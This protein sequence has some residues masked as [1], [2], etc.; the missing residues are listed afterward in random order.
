M[1]NRIKQLQDQLCELRQELSQLES[2]KRDA[3]NAALVGRF[4]K[5]RNCYSCP[6]TESDY[7]W[8]YRK[9]T[10]VS[11]G[12]LETFEFAKDK[13]GKMSVELDGACTIHS[14]WREIDAKEFAAAW[15]DFQTD[16]G[17]LALNAGL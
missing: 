15:D 2:N 7:W 10:G 11:E 13:D 1:S 8:I 12:M 4:F 14:S 6:E 9:V 16:M 17:A 3:E 5:Y